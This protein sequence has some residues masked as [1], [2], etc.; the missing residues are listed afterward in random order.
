MTRARLAIE[1]KKILIL[2]HGSIGDVARA[3]PLAGLLRRR[4]ADAELVWSVEPPSLP[5]VELCRA[6]DEIIVFD[7]PQGAKAFFRFLR[8]IRVRCFDLVLDL[9]RHFKSGLISRWSGAP[10]RLGFHPSDTK[11]LNWLFNN[12]YIEATGDALPKITHYM[13]FADYL[14]IDPRPIEWNLQV[15]AA[16]YARAD[17][18]LGGAQGDCAVL[19][20]GSRWES[21]QWFAAQIA[22]S[23]VEIR[24]RYGLDV[25]FLGTSADQALGD[26][27]E[28]IAQV[29]VVN[30]VGR[31]SLRD[32]VAIIAR[33]RFCVGPDTGLMH[34]AAAMGTPVVSLWGA[35]DPLR[36]GPYSF[37]DLVIQGTADCSPCYR[38][39]CSIGRACMR[40]IDIKAIV[41]MIDKALARRE[42]A[43]D[44]RRD[45]RVSL[46]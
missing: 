32:A 16:D 26:E 23:A 20:V 31:T 35:T 30:L 42:K 38:R 34:I 45:A 36:T 27:A 4:F 46:Y 19:F 8:A 12:R 22:A 21:K 18:L 5:L 6:V 17:K 3:L 43:Q 7:R 44:A 24:R 25:V 1:P 2:L 15:A 13:K 10:N 29:E 11:E 9:Q 41:A 28:R 14:G 37:G 40:S 33:A 39:S